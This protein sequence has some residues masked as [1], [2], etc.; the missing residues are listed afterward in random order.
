MAEPIKKS[1]KQE[2]LESHPNPK[3]AGY[4]KR[5][6]KLEDY[7]NSKSE[8]EEQ[9]V[10]LWVASCVDLFCELELNDQIVQGFMKTFEF[11]PE[12]DASFVFSRSMSETRKMGPLKKT[13]HSHGHLYIS[14]RSQQSDKIY[15]AKIAFTVARTTISKI[16]EQEDIIPKWLLTT[17]KGKTTHQNIASSLEL[18]QKAIL[19]KDADGVIKNSGTLLENILDLETALKP[20]DLSQ[21]LKALFADE[22]MRTRFGIQK[23]FVFALDNSRLVRNQKVIHKSRSLKYEIPFLI[24]ITG[25]YLV[26]MLLEFTI[27]TGKL[28]S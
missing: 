7:L 6:H 12:E 21:K 4:F 5:L 15:Y 13:G 11:E 10:A 3:V 1:T 18:L 2:E 17:F 20:K 9:E 25:A 24:A 14:L 19:A 16:A 28:I 27:S 26:V 8:F 22:S 23:E